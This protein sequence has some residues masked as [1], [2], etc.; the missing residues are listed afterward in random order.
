MRFRLQNLNYSYGQGGEV[1][2]KNVQLN[3]PAG[4]KVAVL[5]MSGSGKTTLLN[6]L[7]LLAS[8][9]RESKTVFYDNGQGVSDYADLSSGQRADFRLNHFGFVLQSAYLLPNFTCRQN[10]ELP[11]VLKGKPVDERADICEKL[12][13]RIEEKSPNGAAGEL[14]TKMKLRPA[15]LSPGQRQRMAVLRAII[16]DPQVVFADEPFASLDPWNTRIVRQLLLDWQSGALNPENP[17]RRRTLLLVTH[18]ISLA[19]DQF[20]DH[21]VLLKDGA[22]IDGDVPGQPFTEKDLPGG[23]QQI[24]AMISPHEGVAA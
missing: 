9:R 1:V 23:H 8:G 19:S 20:A 10:V 21:F 4:A 12:L 17:G 15:R 16:H 22:V 13:K 5:G 2:L 18:N 11:L 7:G 14:S 3:I 24:E 6:I